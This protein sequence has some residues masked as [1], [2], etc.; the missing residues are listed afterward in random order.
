[1]LSQSVVDTERIVLSSTLRPLQTAAVI[2]WDTIRYSGTRLAEIQYTLSLR[3]S[4]T[5]CESTKT[6]RCL[7]NQQRDLP[8]HT[9][10]NVYILPEIFIFFDVI[11]KFIIIPNE[12]IPSLKQTINKT[13]FKQLECDITYKGVSISPRGR[14]RVQPND[15]ATEHVQHM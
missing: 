13:R 4:A 1:M 11:K 12:R 3:D 9:S 2:W 10:V 7:Q 5:P 14:E 6:R 15:G 8:R